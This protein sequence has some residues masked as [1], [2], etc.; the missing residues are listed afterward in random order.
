[1]RRRPTEEVLDFT[2]DVRMDRH[3]DLKYRNL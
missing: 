1:M 2:G 3:M